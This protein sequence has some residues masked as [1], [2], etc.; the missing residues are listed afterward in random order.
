MLDVGRIHSSVWIA[1]C[2]LHA[3]VEAAC[4]YV[5]QSSLSILPQDSSRVA[6]LTS[7]WGWTALSFT[8]TQWQKPECGLLG[9][10]SLQA[11]QQKTLLKLQSEQ[12]E[13]GSGQPE[14]NLLQ[15]CVTTLLQWKATAVEIYHKKW[16][17]QWENPSLA[18]QMNILQVMNM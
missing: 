17:F 3:S 15:Y 9:S 7:R 2:V 13:N 10:C 1:G 18:R 5:Q 14:R 8:P 4:G 6:W 11:Q 16:I 12:K